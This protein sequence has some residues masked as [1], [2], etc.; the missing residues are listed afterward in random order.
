MANVVIWPSIALALVKQFADQ[1]RMILISELLN[2]TSK[3]L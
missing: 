3:V 1:V 2:G